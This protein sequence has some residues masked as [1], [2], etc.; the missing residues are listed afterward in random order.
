MRRSVFP[1]ISAFFTVAICTVVL[2]GVHSASADSLRFLTDLEY[3]VSNN[4]E[5][6]K[7]DTTVDGVFVP[8]G[9]VTESER[10]IFS[11]LYNLD[12]QKEIFPTLRL[13]VGGLFD[14]DSTR[15]TTTD[16]DG[17][18][19]D[20]LN[21]TI[22]PY[23]DLQFSMPLL[24]ASTGYRKSEIKQSS[25]NMVTDR[26]FTEEY[27]ASLSW[28]PIKLPEIDLDFSRNLGDNEPLTNDQRVDTYQLRSRYDYE[29]FR[30]T[31]NHTTNDSLNK[32]TEFKTLTNSD[33]GSIR[34]SRAYQQGK[35]SVNS[36]LRTKR[37]QVKFSGTGERLV[38][39]ISP[40]VVFVNL[41][42]NFPSSNP[43][44]ATEFTDS[45]S[46]IDLFVDT[47]AEA[48]MLSMGLDFGSPTEASTLFINFD[49]TNG[50]NIVG[51]TWQVYH[52][53][54]LNTGQQDWTQIPEVQ[55]Q[56]FY[57]VAENRIELSFPTVKKQYLKVAVTPQVFND[58]LTV[59]SLVAQR[60]LPPDTSEFTSTDWTA[61][62]SVNW[63]HT[64]KTSTGYDILYRDQRTKPFNDKRTLLN[65]GARLRHK[66]NDVFVGSMRGQR[67]ESRDRGENPSTN[68]S[69]SASL[70]AKYLD[71]FDQSLTYSFSHQH[72]EDAR[73]SISN[74]VFLRNNLDLYQGWSMF[75][76][77]GYSWQNPAD[78]ADTNT[79][80]MRV[81]SNIV[82][83]RWINFTLTYGVSWSRETGEPMSRDQNG[84]LV[85]S[86]V[87][88]AA[89][90]LS[91]DLSFTDE[92]G[93]K[94]DS[95]AE[96]R[97]FINWSPFR[98]GDLQF[99]LAYGQSEDTDD[100]K[101][102]TLSPILRW[103]INRNTLLTLD[104]SVGER[105]DPDKVVEFENISLALRIFY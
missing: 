105:D 51:F 66:F 72:D 25:S 86:W 104:Y 101:S 1:R 67:S 17:T 49:P 3:E 95:T 84:R 50:N 9:T 16:P 97:Y 32:M 88:S 98:N 60:V 52:T 58:N 77:N 54:D 10:A 46:D 2:L 71:T 5:T 40:G 102:W 42:D 15:T 65:L 82:P 55:V 74:T 79:T 48:D 47:P 24:R 76:D 87:P 93:E 38:D 44:P 80:F 45:L 29:D 7:N 56:V 28:D 99:S 57:N 13:N 31:Y 19:S 39:T 64:D 26:T 6:T 53:D 35:L 33:N 63:M 78:S 8:E 21:T 37:Q 89:L 81:G 92:T 83:N 18:D 70:A 59:N 34:F 20:S 73:T 69:Y 90:S 61:D 96:Q 43:D 11:Q 30:F 94:K 103:Q 85:V 36:S 68:H 14:Q 91:A 27:T 4:Q 41:D 12:I 100:E 22:R 23:I 75:L 62:T